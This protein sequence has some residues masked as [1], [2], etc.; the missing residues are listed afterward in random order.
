MSR[1]HG[2]WIGSVVF[3]FLMGHLVAQT[4]PPVP[5]SEFPKWET[6]VAQP[7]ATSTGPLSPDGR[8]LVYG[9]TRQNRDNELRVVD[10]AGGRTT[11]LALG[12]QPVFS[13]DSK[14]LAYAIGV[15]EAEE[16]KLQKAKKPVRRSLGIVNLASATTTTVDA[17]ESFAFSADGHQLAMR[18]YPPDPPR[19][20]GADAAS[21]APAESDDRD[22]PGS[23]LIVRDLNIGSDTT[24]GNIT[25]F[26]WQAKGPL[27][28]FAV[29]VE[30]RRGNGVQLYNPAT[31]ALRVLDSGEANYSNLAWRKDA[32]DLAVMRS[33]SDPTRDGPT[34]MVMA[35]RGLET[36]AGERRTFDPA[37]SAWLPGDRRIVSFRKPEWSKDG[38]TL[39]VGIAEWFPG[40]G[41][42]KPE[43]DSDDAAVDVWHWKDADVMPL[44]KKRLSTD[45]QRNMLAAWHVESGAFVPLARTLLED[46]RVLDGQPRALVVDR[47]AFAME[48]SIGRHY[49][50]VALIDLATGARIPVKEH[51]E[52]QYLQASPDGRFLLYFLDD[53]YW[54]YDIAASAH[55]NLTRTI[56][57]SFAD[58]QSDQTVKQKPPFGVGGWTKESSAVLLYDKYD[59]WE[60]AT[61]GAAATRLTNGAAEQIRHRIVRLDPDERVVDRGKALYMTI[62]GE[63][64]K[65]NGFARLAPAAVEVEKV[66]W[67]EKRVNRLTRAKDTDV[68]AY[69]VE[70]F[71][72]SSDY[73]VSGPVLGDAR[74]VTHTN[75]QQDTYSWGRSETVEYKNARGERTQ[76]ALFYPAGY[77]PGKRYPMVVYMYE[78]LSDT[79]HNYVSPSERSPYNAS[80]F[81]AQGYFFFAPDIVFRPREPGVSV[82]ESVVP[83]VKAVIAR[84][85]VDAARVG[86]VGHSWGGFDTVY[87]ATHTDVFAAAVAGAPITNLV[88]NYGNHH[89][90]QGIAE[91]DHIETGQQRMEVPLWEDLPAYIRNSAVYS[92]HTMKTPLLVAFG[93]S[94]GTVFWHQGVELYNIARR[95]GKRVVMLTYAGEDHGLRKRANQLDYQQRILQWF[96]HYLKGETAQAW[97]ERGVTAL[98]RDRE[99]K[100]V[101]PPPTN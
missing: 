98:E 45:R 12:E 26:A 100:K 67:L 41:T 63:W 33:K 88:S 40:T 8:F 55:R 73:R 66:V 20:P 18:V 90:S 84:G 78:L 19:A 24:F 82:V 96:G 15:S 51:I 58:K 92:A 68:Y 3:L 65:K 57:T 70:D 48:R 99:L 95:A 25:E 47:G 17:I 72:D 1:S 30:G 38:R 69:V 36:R 54:I 22:K 39:F 53:H 5:S 49:A 31:G 61:S 2:R 80:V 43:A 4:K 101:T 29:G 64:T 23:A 10:I 35:W 94:D 86:I 13:A 32:D 27:L 6:L 81:T 85:A 34:Q 62:A 42:T 60:V 50:D 97:I 76:G 28:A 91:T 77:E 46:V 37:S 9:I 75:P 89:W 56:A 52:D 11:V 71:D 83:G 59:V 93:E 7:R 44:Q 16:E 74:D 79:V 21:P 14:W 87:L